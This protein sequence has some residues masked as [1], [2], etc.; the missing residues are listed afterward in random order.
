MMNKKLS[1]ATV[2]SALGSLLFGFDTAVISGTT[3]SI[4][5]YF[6]LTDA[7]I[8]MTV[9]TTLWGTVSWLHCDRQAW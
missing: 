8:G 1:L 3:K 5:G 9:S 4:M 7:T 6:G 2:V